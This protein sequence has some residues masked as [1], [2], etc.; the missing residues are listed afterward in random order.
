MVG[1]LGFGVRGY[2]GGSGDGTR[3]DIFQGH[4]HSFIGSVRPSSDENLNF[5]FA[6]GQS[7]EAVFNPDGAH[8]HKP[9]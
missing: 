5:D 4:G 6:G 1:E 8:I 7:R 9:D 3:R 2:R